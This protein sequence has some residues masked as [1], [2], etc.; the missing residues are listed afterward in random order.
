[1]ETNTYQRFNRS[2]EKI[3]E[4]VEDVDIMAEIGNKYYLLFD[5][6]VSLHLF[7]KILLHVNI[8]C[9]QGD[10]GDCPCEALIPKYQL[11]DLCG[12]AAKLNTLGAMDSIPTDKATRLLTILERNIRDGAKVCPISDPVSDYLIDKE[13][14][15]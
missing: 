15:A 12:E 3:F 1:M 7:I 8:T 11:Q 9:F 5:I 2:M 4:D 14:T 10:E 6:R 13:Y